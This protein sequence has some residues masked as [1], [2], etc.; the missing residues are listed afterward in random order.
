MDFI[1]FTGHSKTTENLLKNIK[2]ISL[3]PKQLIENLSS[4]NI[5]TSTIPNKN[6]ISLDELPNTIKMKVSA[7]NKNNGTTMSKNLI[8]NFPNI[9][10][11]GEFF[12]LNFQ[13]Y[14]NINM[15]IGKPLIFNNGIAHTKLGL[16]RNTRE[17][18][19][20][21]LDIKKIELETKFSNGFKSYIN[22][23][24]IRMGLEMIQKLNIFYNQSILK[25]FGFKIDTKV[26]MTKA[27]KLIPF[28]KLIAGKKIL[29]E[30]NSLFFE[31]G[32]KVGKIFGQTGLIEKFFLGDFL[33]GYK[34][35]S[36]GP[37]NQN[38]KIG[39]NSFIEIRN[40][41]GFYIKKFEIFAF[42][43]VGVSSVKGLRECGDIL[44]SFGD[45]NCIGKSVG[46]GV[47]LKNK[48]GPSFIFA[49]PLTTSSECEKYVVGVDFEF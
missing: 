23:L 4:L 45:N 10:G 36:I 48:K 21:E 19:D 35:E 46:L 13:N 47:S 28:V 42:G 14:N 24:K 39:G 26:G 8:V 7:K 22:D 31:S 17:I 32:V 1:Q 44:M 34:K 12:N 6:K 5:F 41:I 11:N 40:K 9:F 33:R 49:V 15:E 29:F 20:K 16:K 30:G 43:D 3:S 27:D 37:V 2:S 38:K 18:N 25:I